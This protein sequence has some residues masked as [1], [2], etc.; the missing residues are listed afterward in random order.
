MPEVSLDLVG[1]FGQLGAIAIVLFFLW[2]YALARLE[3]GDADKERQAAKLEETVERLQRERDLSK[4]SV[5]A[6]FGDIGDAF[7]S[8]A[9]DLKVLVVSEVAV[10]DSRQEERTQRILKHIDGTVVE[11][12]SKLDGYASGLRK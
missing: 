10:H 9:T 4:D 6:A 8:L 3:K 7:T 5:I 11:L 12:C 1:Y 2:K